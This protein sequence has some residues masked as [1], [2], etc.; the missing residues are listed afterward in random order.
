MDELGITEGIRSGGL[1]HDKALSHLYSN[2]AY[3]L[4]VISV[5]RSKGLSPTDSDS[6][7]TDLVIQFGKLVISGKYDAQGTLVGY[8][9][10]LARYMVLNHFR[11]NKK[12]RHAELNDEIYNI[13][14]F[15]DLSVYNDELKG[16]LSKQLDLIGG[17]CKEIL[18]LWS[19]NYSM[20]EIMKK[21]SIVSPEATRKR[22]HSCLKKLL[23]SV[24]KDEVIQNQLKEYLHN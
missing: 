18:M 1:L 14:D 8:L 15:D 6:L 19:R 10:N 24:S 23:D 3:K 11:D 16:L 21:M 9:K 7:W 4:P 12:Y 17:M 20:S 5:M 2:S 22:K 13:G